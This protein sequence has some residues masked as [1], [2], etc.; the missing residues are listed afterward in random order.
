MAEA[1]TQLSIDDYVAFHSKSEE[2]AAKL[3]ARIE[4]LQKEIA[5][6]EDVIRIMQNGITSATL[7]R[8]FLG[9]GPLDSYETYDCS[10]V[11]N[12]LGINAML[13]VGDSLGNPELV[14]EYDVA[15]TYGRVFTLSSRGGLVQVYLARGRTDY[16][17]DM[18]HGNGI[19]YNNEEAKRKRLVLPVA[20]LKCE[21]DSYDSLLIHG[22]VSEQTLRAGIFATVGMI[23][24]VTMLSDEAEYTR[25]NN[26]IDKAIEYH[27][28]A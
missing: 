3:R 2:E 5:S 23:D 6:G 9:I 25:L 24:S 19:M 28:A 17:I 26:V 12:E 11:S 10:F 16:P 8:P 7:S 20:D 13:S 14:L 21:F 27:K 15:A 18:P 4:G 22:F 1:E